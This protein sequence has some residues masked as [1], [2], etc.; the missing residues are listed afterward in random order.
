M[1]VQEDLTLNLWQIQNYD[2]W[3]V[4]CEKWKNNYQIQTQ[5]QNLS[6]KIFLD[7]STFYIFTALEKSKPVC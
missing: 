1:H 4:N 2:V 5:K 3:H 7:E 6:I